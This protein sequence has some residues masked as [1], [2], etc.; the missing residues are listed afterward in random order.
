MH[1]AECRLA[2]LGHL[3]V[4]VLLIGRHQLGEQGLREAQRSVGVTGTAANVKEDMKNATRNK[5]KEAKLQ[6]DLV[7][8]LWP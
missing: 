5:K 3:E 2:E 4:Y 8:R 1:N 6:P 7:P